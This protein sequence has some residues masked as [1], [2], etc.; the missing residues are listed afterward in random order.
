MRESNTISPTAFTGDRVVS[1]KCQKINKYLSL[2]HVIICISLKR[3][4]IGTKT[5][6]HQTQEFSLQ[7]P[8]ICGV[9]YG[10]GLSGNGTYS[11]NERKISVAA[12][13]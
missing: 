9:T 11:S 6:D 12:A 10:G 4:Q 7:S 3:S 1:G 13:A 8:A 5:Y 2:L